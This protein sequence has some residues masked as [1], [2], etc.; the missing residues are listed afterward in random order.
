MIVYVLMSGMDFE[1]ATQ[2]LGVY[3]TL[4]DAKAHSDEHVRWMEPTSETSWRC[5]SS[6]V[7]IQEHEVK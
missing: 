6:W 5:S 3:R 2:I 7:E 1:D 4:E